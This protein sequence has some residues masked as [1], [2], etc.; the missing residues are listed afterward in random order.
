MPA[1]ACSAPIAP[2]LMIRPA[3]EAV[4]YGIAAREAFSAVVTLSA[5]MRAHVC[6][7]P[8]TT[9]SYANPPAM[10]T[11]ASILPKCDATAS[12]AFLGRPRAGQ[13]DTAEFEPVCRGRKLCRRVV[14]TRDPCAAR[15][16]LI[17]N[18]LAE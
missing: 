1:P 3:L 10:L 15:Q 4:R 11:S 13:I 16:S 6:G 2:T 14:D 9:V 8:S 18:H 7:S 5:Y 17:G 12:I